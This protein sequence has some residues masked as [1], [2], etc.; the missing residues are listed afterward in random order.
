MKPSAKEIRTI[1]YIKDK[2]ENKHIGSKVLS[3]KYIDSKSKLEI[4]C[5]HGHKFEMSWG[6]ISQNR[7]CSKCIGTEKRTFEDIKNQIENV[8]Y[9][10]SN[11]ISASYKN[12]KSKL[13]IQCKHGHKFEM[14]WSFITQDRWCPKC[15]SLVR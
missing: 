12:T 7:W 9:P 15:S 1:E 8:L 13:E 3:T 6:D 4:K 2:I 5:E 11:L 14:S 10:G